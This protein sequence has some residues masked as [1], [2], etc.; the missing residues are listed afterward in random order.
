MS[1]SLVDASDVEETVTE[2]LAQLVR[3][4]GEQ[5]QISVEWLQKQVELQLEYSEGSL[6]RWKIGSLPGSAQEKSTQFQN[7]VATVKSLT[8]ETPES[9]HLVVCCCIM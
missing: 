2:V 5:A 6:S 1:E 9:S 8:R 4:G 3:D 7:D